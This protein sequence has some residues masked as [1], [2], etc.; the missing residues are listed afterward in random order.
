M[1]KNIAAMGD[2]R[3]CLI[4][5]KHTGQLGVVSMKDDAGV[6]FRVT[7][8]ERTLIDITVRPYYAGGV[9]EVLEAFRRAAIG[10]AL[11]GEKIG[12]RG[13]F[14]LGIST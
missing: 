13:M 9:G 8:L 4:N 10:E 11:I 14:G 3:L 12:E 1:T 2:Y 5:G 6:E 7:G